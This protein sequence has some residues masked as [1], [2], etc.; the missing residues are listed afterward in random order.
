MTGRSLT[1]KSHRRDRLQHSTLRERLQAVKASRC[2]PG[3]F[4]C[5]T[6]AA[7]HPRFQIKPTRRGRE[8]SDSQL[9]SLTKPNHEGDKR[10]C[11]ERY[12][13]VAAKWKISA[14]VITKTCE[15][16]YAI[17]GGILEAQ[18]LQNANDEM[19]CLHPIHP[20]LALCNVVYFAE[21]LSKQIE[22]RYRL[23]LGQ[24][25]AANVL[26]GLVIHAGA[27]VN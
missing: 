6:L 17:M 14:R 26:D 27:E 25:A 18:Y 5:R 20:R 7:P 10:R 16:N 22:E 2:F 24:S 23:A 13:E 21:N 1:P 15:R 4:L 8:R 11:D 3:K 12:G 9:A 19:G